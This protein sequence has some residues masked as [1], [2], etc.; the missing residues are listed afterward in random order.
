MHT[1]ILIRRKVRRAT[2]SRRGSYSK[3]HFGNPPELAVTGRWLS[4]QSS[5]SGGSIVTVK[6]F[7]FFHII[8]FIFGMF[9]VTILYKSIADR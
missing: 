9:P 7:F 3:E 2:F 5:V 4:L 8:I 6:V 1:E